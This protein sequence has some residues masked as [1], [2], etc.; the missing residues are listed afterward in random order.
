MGMTGI[1]NTSR[2]LWLRRAPEHGRP[3][4]AMRRQ[5]IIVTVSSAGGS[6]ISRTSP[7]EVSASSLALTGCVL[8]ASNASSRAM[9]SILGSLTKALQPTR[10]AEPSIPLE[11]A[12][13]A[14]AAE[15]QR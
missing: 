2:I 12:R 1:A 3:R 14:R 6:C 11:P 10:A 13:P 9:N 5:P 15:R 7:R 4:A 8:S